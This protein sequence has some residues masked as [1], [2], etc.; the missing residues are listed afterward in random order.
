[1]KAEIKDYGI[2]SEYLVFYIKSASLQLI[3][4]FVFTYGY[5]IRTQLLT[6][7]KSSDKL[8]HQ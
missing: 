8:L 2:L 1:M 6:N 3:E 4:H 5:N 7:I